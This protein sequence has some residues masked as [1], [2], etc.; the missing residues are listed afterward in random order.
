MNNLVATYLNDLGVQPHHKVLV[1]VSGGL[2]S[3]VMATI[4]LELKFSIGI[5]H[6]NFGLRGAEADA[7]QLFVEQ[8]GA[9]HRVLVY[10]T[11]VETKQYAQQHGIS[12]QMAARELRY[13]WFNELTAQ[14]G[15]DFIATGHHLNDSLETAL[16]NLSRGT[17]L[18]GLAGIAP[19]SGSRIRPLLRLTRQQIE[20]YAA[21]KQIAWREDGSNQTDAYLRNFIRHRVI[22]QLKKVN[23]TLENSFAE[24]TIHLQADLKLLQHNLHQWQTAHVHQRGD[25]LILSVAS[26][27]NPHIIPY[28]W[29]TLQ[30]YG[31]G[32]EQ[33]QAI[34]AAATGQPGK[35]FFSQTHVLAIDRG[36]L[37]ITRRV[38]TPPEV[39]VSLEPGSYVMGTQT[40]EL[41]LPV[42]VEVITNPE[43]A[44]LDAEKLAPTLVWRVWQPGDYFYPLGMD[45]RKKVSDFLVDEKIPVNKKGRVTVL[46][47][48][49]EIVWIAGLRID[50]RFKL[51]KISRQAVLFR[52]TQM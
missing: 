14:H 20:V 28:L 24:T 10:S 34:L 19:R 46:E 49:G 39:V 17:G 50:N 43:V 32:W 36:E 30:A 47:S 12:I 51:T 6:V 41:V 37:L 21:E 48:A 18:E 15:Y 9:L 27:S 23:P 35:Q 8:W 22:P 52:V 31:F 33:T 45:K 2:D 7:D 44:V 42:A 29:R 5:A 4:L 11:Q 40:L 13:Q 25:D 26:L 38:E 1:A 3:M 16:I